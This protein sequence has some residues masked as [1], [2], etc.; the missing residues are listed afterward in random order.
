[1]QHLETAVRSSNAQFHDP[2]FL[3]RLDIRLLEHSPGEK[4]WEIFALDY[5]VDDLSPLATVFT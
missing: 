1:M 4:G 3:G 2:E 5:K